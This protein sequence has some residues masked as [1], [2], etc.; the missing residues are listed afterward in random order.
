MC[1]KFNENNEMFE[2]LVEFIGLL[3]KATVKVLNIEKYL[4]MIK[5][6]TQLK[7]ILE[8][9]MPVGE[10]NIEI[11]DV[12]N[13]GSVSVETDTMSVTD[14]KEFS[15]IVA[16]ADNFEIFSLVNG[17]FQFNITYQGVLNSV[18]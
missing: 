13:L 1:E 7:E 14:T 12:F 17:N 16:N 2:A 5:S 9:T 6:A 8:K 4:L 18:C 3:P 10:M 15:N 11:D